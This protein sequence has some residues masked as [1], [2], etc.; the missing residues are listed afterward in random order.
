MRTIASRALQSISPRW[1]KASV[2]AQVRS[3]MRK[4]DFAYFN[5]FNSENEISVSQIQF[6][7][8]FMCFL[9]EKI[10]KNKSLVSY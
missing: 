6:L 4:E 10:S 2:S 7:L 3:R 5:R 9:F 8:L 1:V